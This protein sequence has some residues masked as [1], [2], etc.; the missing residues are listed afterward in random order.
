[1]AASFDPDKQ[2]IVNQVGNGTGPVSNCKALEKSAGVRLGAGLPALFPWL[3]LN[4]DADAGRVTTSGRQGS[5][6]ILQ[7]VESAARQLVELSLHYLVNQPGRICV[8]G[9]QSASQFRCHRR[10]S[11]DDR[12][13]RCRSRHPVPAPGGRA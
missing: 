1:V 6:I 5:N 11:A 13:R 3:K 12:V 4:A 8:M 9:Q 7:P 10:E 2:E